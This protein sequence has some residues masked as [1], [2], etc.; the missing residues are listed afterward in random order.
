MKRIAIILIVTV[1]LVACSHKLS[2][3]LSPSETFKLS[4][5]SA[6]TSTC[7]IAPG[8]LQ[9]KAL[10]NWLSEN[11]NGW[12]STPASYV[13]GTVVSGVGFTLNFVG[14]LAIANYSGGQYSRSTKPV[15]Y[16]FLQ[17]K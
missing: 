16:E 5:L 15:D 3:N 12:Q 14:S 6:T 7:L 11:Q 13:P 8:S 4:T 9:H 1:L 17:C 2:L 10:E